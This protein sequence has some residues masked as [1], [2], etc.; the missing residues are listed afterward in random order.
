MRHLRE[1]LI[2][3]LPLLHEIDLFPPRHHS[4]SM[5]RPPLNGFPPFFI[6]RS[7]PFHYTRFNVSYCS[8]ALS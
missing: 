7:D 6:G 5:E 2:V 8:R 4:P 3:N 1:S